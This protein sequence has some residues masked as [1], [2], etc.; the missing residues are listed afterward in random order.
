MIQIS[1]T[2]KI[3]CL[4]LKKT[5]NKDLKGISPWLN[6][7]KIAL[8]KTKLFLLAQTMKAMMQTYKSSSS[9]KRFVYPLK[10]HISQSFYQPTPKLENHYK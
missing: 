10:V 9:E 8:K 4:S 5:L 7:N 1:I 3:P 6:N 2:S